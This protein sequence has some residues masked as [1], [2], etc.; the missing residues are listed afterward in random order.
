MQPRGFS[1][2]FW[3]KRIDKGSAKGC[4]LYLDGVCADGTERSL[5]SG[6]RGAPTL[7]YDRARRLSDARVQVTPSARL[8]AHASF[9][10]ERIEVRVNVDSITG[11][12]AG[13]TVQVLL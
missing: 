1:H 11:G 9:R 6:W 13:R 12:A 4:G 7:R 8:S 5:G 3:R 2:D 10:P